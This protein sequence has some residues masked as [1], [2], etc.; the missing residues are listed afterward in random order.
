MKSFV[1]KKH[2]A[3]IKGI[4]EFI[5]LNLIFKVLILDYSGGTKFLISFKIVKVIMSHQLN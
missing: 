4:S 5:E 1:S 2:C 3:L